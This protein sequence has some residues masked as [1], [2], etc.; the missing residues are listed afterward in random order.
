MH[1]GYQKDPLKTGRWLKIILK[2]VFFCLFLKLLLGSNIWEA[3]YMQP[4][5]VFESLG[6]RRGDGKG[7]THRMS[8]PLSRI[9]LPPENAK[10]LEE[11]AIPVYIY[12]YV[13][14]LQ[15]CGKNYGIWNLR[16]GIW[17]HDNV[18]LSN[19]ISSSSVSSFVKWG[20]VEKQRKYKSLIKF[21]TVQ[22][23]IN[24]FNV[25]FCERIEATLTYSQDHTGI[26]NKI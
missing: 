1:T 22:V 6:N 26:T 21:S 11:I 25:G 18:I 17:C 12:V 4:R 23:L 15:S 10:F 3:Q 16:W 9:T 13:L 14:N 5:Q 7:G 20:H 2:V 19:F 24:F 8:P